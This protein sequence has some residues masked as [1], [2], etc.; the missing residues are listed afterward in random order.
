MNFFEF[1]SFILRQKS[2]SRREKIVAGIYFD[3]LLFFS[4]QKSVGN[5]EKT[6]L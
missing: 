6:S 3:F 4:M 5:T 1:L 2:V